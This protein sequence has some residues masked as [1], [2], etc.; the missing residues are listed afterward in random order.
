MRR[1]WLEVKESIE[2]LKTGTGSKDLIA[3]VVVEAAQMLYQSGK[4]EGKSFTELVELSLETL[5]AG[6]AFPYFEKMVLAHGGNVDVCTDFSKYPH[7]AKYSKQLRSPKSGYILKIDGLLVGNLCVQLGAGRHVAD[8]DVDPI[9]GMEFFYREGDRIEKDQVL[10]TVQT[11]ISQEVLDRVCDTLQDS[12]EFS[13]IPVTIPFVISH[14]VTKD[15]AEPF[16]VP[17]C[18]Q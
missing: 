10:V 2:L 12:I 17:E 9:A 1:I 7:K 16:V 18:L 3:L 11:S 5:K 6:T 15:G 13:D 8:Q 14:R 4:Y